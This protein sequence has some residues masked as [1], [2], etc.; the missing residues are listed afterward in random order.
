M[1]R[2]PGHPPPPFSE[3]DSVGKSSLVWLHF[4]SVTEQP[5]NTVTTNS[6]DR[7]GVFLNTE[8]SSLH[9]AYLPVSFCQHS[10]VLSKA[11]NEITF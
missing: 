5:K 7:L 1:S 9:T 6:G 2:I 11:F 8:I 10:L 3:G 4:L